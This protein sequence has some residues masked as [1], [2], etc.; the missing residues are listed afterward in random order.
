M[1]LVASAHS[2]GYETGSVLALVLLAGLVL[3]CGQRALDRSG[4]RDSRYRRNAAIAGLVFAA[5]LVAATVR[6]VDQR[7]AGPWDTQQGRAL[8]ADFVAGCLR[9]TNGSATAISVCE[10]LFKQT[11]S[12][13]PYDTPAGFTSLASV[14]E[15]GLRDSR[16]VPPQLL[17][18]LAACR[19]R[20]TG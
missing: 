13:P 3:L 2:A 19:P 16:S 18:A 6:F 4:T 10:C 1:V 14:V 11:A 12:T 20:Q 15:A 17:A 8:H 5:L 7:T 9:G